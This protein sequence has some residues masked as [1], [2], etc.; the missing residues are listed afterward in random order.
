MAA[1][2]AIGDKFIEIVA[3]PSFEDKAV[4]N[5]MKKKSRRLLEVS[6]FLAKPIQ[7]L[8]LRSALGG[9]LAQSPDVDSEEKFETVTKKKPT[10]AEFNAALFGWK[11]AK[12]VRSNAI[13]FSREDRTIGIGA[14]QMSRV[15]SCRI[16]VEK[17]KNA[18][19]DV[20]G[21][22]MASDAMFPFR[23]S[24]DYAAQAGA[25]TV[26]QPG[27]SIRDAESITAADEHG[28][29]MIFT[30]ARHFRH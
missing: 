24:V 21:T 16:A 5:L 29:S 11:I 22:A 3:A 23:D 2:E 7:P 15:D 26:I 17:A 9:V 18:G 10:E 1:A 20:K 30:H 4:E 27:G 13:V 28:I 6:E 8:L 12:H 14:G 25:T 19:L